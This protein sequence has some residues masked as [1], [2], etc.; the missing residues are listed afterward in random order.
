MLLVSFLGFARQHSYR[1][2]GIFTPSQICG[3]KFRCGKFC[4]APW[5]LCGIPRQSPQCALLVC[6]KFAENP[7]FCVRT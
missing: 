5:I 3:G 1:G 7:E 4:R 6:K 2:G